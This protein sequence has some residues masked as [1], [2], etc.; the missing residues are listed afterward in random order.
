MPKSSIASLFGPSAEEIVYARQ[1][2]DK[3]LRDQE[4][5]AAL[6]RQQ[7]PAAQSYY[8]AGYN[9]AKGLGGL[10][11]GESVMVDPAL[12][13]AV[14][15]RDMVAKLEGKDFNDSKVLKN[16]AE[17]LADEGYINEAIRIYDRAQAIEVQERTLA[18]E[19]GK[20]TKLTSAYVDVDGNPVMV[21]QTTGE[22]FTPEGVPIPK[23]EVIRSTEYDDI[24][25]RQLA[26][27]RVK[28]KKKAKTDLEA[29]IRNAADP[30][31][32]SPVTGGQ[33]MPGVMGGRTG[34]E[35]ELNKRLEAEKAAREKRAADIQ[36]VPDLYEDTVSDVEEIRRQEQMRMGG[37]TDPSYVS[38]NN[39]GR[40]EQTLLSPEQAYTFEQGMTPGLMF[41]PRRASQEDVVIP[42]WDIRYQNRF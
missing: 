36:G 29:D 32:W 7:S 11:G 24:A 34:L 16:L 26:I 41:D 22:F 42:P 20:R 33:G 19:E 12:K 14:K 9:L 21:N 30:N 23:D 4:Y 37:V 27:D 2:Q 25:T 15:M 8:A 40:V 39:L 13:K 38:P 5:Q 10:L 17:K 35:Q 1:Q 31:Q 6:A 18:I 3:I 28:N